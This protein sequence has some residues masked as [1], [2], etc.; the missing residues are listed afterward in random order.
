MCTNKGKNTKYIIIALNKTVPDQ[1]IRRK[2]I[3]NEW[4][5]LMRPVSVTLLHA[6]ISRKNQMKLVTRVVI[7]TKCNMSLKGYPHDF[8]LDPNQAK[9]CAIY[10]RVLSQI[11]EGMRTVFW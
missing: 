3:L 9:L 5:W 1:I 6:V 10:V 7:R 11:D 4:F 2:K 8:H